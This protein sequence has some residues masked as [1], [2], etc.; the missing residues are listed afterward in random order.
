MADDGGGGGTT[1]VST[2]IGSFTVAMAGDPIQ[3]EQ[4]TL[5]ERIA[6]SNAKIADMQEKEK[7]V[8]EDIPSRET[9]IV[10]AT[11]EKEKEIIES[12]TKEKETKI[13]DTTKEKETKIVDTTKEKETK[14]VDTTKEK[15][16]KIVDTTTKEKETKIVDITK[17]KEKEIVDITKEKEKEIVDTTTKEKESEIVE[18]TKEKESES[19]AVVEKALTG[20]QKIAEDTQATIKDLARQMMAL[21]ATEG[22]SEETK[23]KRAELGAERIAAIEKKAS[24]QRLARDIESDKI[25]E[26]ARIDP[27]QIEAATPQASMVGRGERTEE[28]KKH[29]TLLGKIVASNE[30]MA[31]AMTTQSNG[32]IIPAS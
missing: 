1:A 3:K 30:R 2:A 17:E 31:D 16:T 20:M 26:A 6:N 29:S 28:Q 12:T 11:K 21:G 18:E 10:E 27:K 15:E 19:V 24:L 32:A 23:A 4:T 9:K 8:K 13:V 7:A 25:R 22:Q 5:L 14:I